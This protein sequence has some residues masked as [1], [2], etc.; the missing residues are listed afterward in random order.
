VTAVTLTP[1]MVAV[2][3]DLC[4][5]GMSYAEIATKHKITDPDLIRRWA[6][7]KCFKEEHASLQKEIRSQR[8]ALM[9]HASILAAKHLVATLDDDSEDKTADRNTAAQIALRNTNEQPG[10]VSI[11]I[12]PRGIF[13]APPDELPPVPVLALEEPADTDD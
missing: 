2:L 3:I 5:G 4:K 8:A 12:E 9:D 6:N 10:E 11:T 7:L 1:L 13:A